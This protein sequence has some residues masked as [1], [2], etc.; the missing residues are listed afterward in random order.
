V[1][2]L[3]DS[4]VA[5]GVKQQLVEA[6]YD[7]ESV[8]DW[9][10][11]PGDDAILRYAFDNQRILVTLDKGF[12]ELAVVHQQPHCGIMRLVYV[13]P[14][15]QGAAVIETLQSFGDQLEKGAI[16]AVEP[17]R[18]RVRPADTDES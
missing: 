8:R 12:G 1:K 4:C 11:D 15:K 6:G 18:V 14:P 9:D 16:V 3:L 13:R 17:F 2:V 7:A 5:N 10:A